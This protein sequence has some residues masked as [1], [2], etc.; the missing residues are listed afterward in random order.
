MRV[1]HLSDSYLPL[2][3]G[4]ETQVAHLARRQV[5]AGH[6]VDVV[7]TTPSEPGARGCTTAVQ[8]DGVR[9]HRIAAR[10]PGGF[11][12]HPRSTHHLLALVERL[13]AA[14]ERPDVVHVHMGMLAPTA[15]AALRPLTRRGLPTVLTVHSVWG[16]WWRAFAAL[17][18]VTRWSRW[19]VAYTAVSHLAAGFV[20]RAAHGT[21]VT[22]LRNGVDLAWR[23]ERVP[24]GERPT[25]ALHV[26][27]AN[28]FAPRKRVLPMLEALRSAAGRLPAGALR[29]TVA[30]EG[31]EL[32]AARRY[33]A[34]HRLD[35]VELPGRLSPEAL[36]DLYA[37]ADVYL[38]PGVQDAFSVAVQ[39]AWAAGLAVVSRS[40]SGAAELLEDGVSGLLAAD[41]D[42]FADAVVRLATDRALLERVVE[43][44]RSAAPPTAWPQVLADTDAAYRRAAELAR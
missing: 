32:D 21:P 30:G 41:D 38:A 44:N 15:Q 14:G 43:H 20:E 39:E 5:A 7:T 27:A 36:H 11:P 1:L 25:Q 8:D 31:P 24:P 42:A 18:R 13:A 12:V 10:V 34:Q 40:Q 19:P 3:G 33:V 16:R 6:Q 29:A 2:L 4:I 22:V 35:W 26:V 23:A 9:V 17:D 37:R 28:R